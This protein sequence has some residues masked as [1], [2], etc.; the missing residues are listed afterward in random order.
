MR[1][2]N[3]FLDSLQADFREQRMW[4]I[5][6]ATWFFLMSLGGGLYV[7]RWILGV[8]LGAVYGLFIV[9]L[10][11]LIAIGIGGFVLIADLGRPLRLLKALRNFR[12]SWISVGAIADFIFV[13][14]KG[15]YLAPRF[16]IQD[17]RPFHVLTAIQ[18]P[19]IEQTLI[20]IAGLSALIVMVYAGLVLASTRAIP[21]WRSLLIPAQFFF[22]GF[23]TAVAFL[24][25]MSYALGQTLNQHLAQLKMILIVMLILTLLCSVAR[26][27]TKQPVVDYVS[28]SVER[29]VRGD[30][31][32][33]Y[34]GGVLVIGH[35]VPVILTA[36]L[37]SQDV[38][39]GFLAVGVM[40]L[41]GGFLLRY[42]T[43]RAGLFPPLL[44]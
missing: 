1:G 39:M 20:T 44:S 37:A 32:Q 12:T 40:V 21:Y 3:P 27:L 2:Q 29:L 43:L 33:F 23:S 36:I 42:T 16:A 28:E 6:H 38:T 5:P 4:R 11:A 25:I 7:L 24:F 9:D 30:L 8:S 13:V 31:A 17:F 34:I 26:L 14:A 22:S 10:A 41:I 18:A 19:M 15:I 35:L